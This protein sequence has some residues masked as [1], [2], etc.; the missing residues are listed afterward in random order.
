MR[1]LGRSKENGLDFREEEVY[2]AVYMYSGSRWN[3]HQSFRHVGVGRR[4]NLDATCKLS[5]PFLYVNI[6]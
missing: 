2:S 3:K 4:E 6:S 5:S 1:S